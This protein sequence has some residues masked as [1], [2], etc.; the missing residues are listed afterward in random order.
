MVQAARLEAAKARG[1]WELM[2]HS[3]LDPAQHAAELAVTAAVAQ[4]KRA[5]EQLEKSIRARG[6]LS[7]AQKAYGAALV[8]G[9]GSIQSPCECGGRSWM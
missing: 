2:K 8:S 3:K 9:C 7:T 5:H 1:A 4:R 6:E